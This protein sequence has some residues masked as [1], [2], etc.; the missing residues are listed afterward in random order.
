MPVTV[1]T[2]AVPAAQT[3][4]KAVIKSVMA[5]R[6]VNKMN[7]ASSYECSHRIMRSVE[8][9]D[10][11]VVLSLLPLLFSSSSLVLLHC[12]TFIFF[13]FSN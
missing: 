8:L 10:E 9:V 12:R 2:A 5:V 13:R 7:L 6:I 3:P 1:M 4:F 11:G